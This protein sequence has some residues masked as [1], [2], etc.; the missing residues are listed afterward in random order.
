MPGQPFTHHWIKSKTICQFLRNFDEFLNG[1]WFYSILA[2]WS[3]VFLN[4]S[5]NCRSFDTPDTPG[6]ASAVIWNHCLKQIVA[7]HP[8]VEYNSRKKI[9]LL[10][11][12][13]FRIAVDRVAYVF[14]KGSILVILQNQET[15][16]MQLFVVVWNIVL[17]S[18]L[19]RPMINFVDIAISYWFELEYIVS[20]WYSKVDGLVS[21]LRF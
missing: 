7:I 9:S 2:G 5:Q 1:F 10:W 18:K 12:H 11:Q 4:F 15:C 13:N 8:T 19:T 14:G 16:I 3:W 17:L 20:T 6:C 21:D